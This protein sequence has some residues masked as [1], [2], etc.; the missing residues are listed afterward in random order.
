M[1]ATL[2]LFEELLKGKQALKDDGPLSLDQL[3]ARMNEKI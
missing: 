2:T 1:K 3:K